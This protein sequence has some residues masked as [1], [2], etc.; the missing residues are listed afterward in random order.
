MRDNRPQEAKGLNVV[1]SVVQVGMKCGWQKFDSLNDNGIDGIII[2]RKLSVDTGDIYYTQIKCGDGY[3]STTLKRP[4]T[5]GINLGD[6]YIKTHRQRWNKLQGPTILVYVDFKTGK[7]W[8]TN[9]KSELSY[10]NENRNIILI[11][12]KN[13]FGKHSIGDLRKLRNHV[14]LDRDLDVIKI[15][16]NELIIGS[17]KDSLKKTARSFYNK[18]SDSPKKEKRNPKLGYIMV[19]RVGWRHI[20]RRGRG[21]ENIIQSWQLLG[22][23]KEIIQTNDKPYQIRKPDII[24]TDDTQ[25]IHDY[26]SL[27]NRVVFPNRQESVIQV[28]LERKQEIDFHSGNITSRIWFYSVHEPRKGKK[29]L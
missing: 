5:I 21:M 17:L 4:K 23:A 14:D 25:M 6:N 18:W 26:L 22:V 15:S 3:L 9:L 7:S 11:D 1:Q 10:T 2:D 27:R 19:S 12:K 24:R 8:W 28:V 20:T 29:I 13:S 16:K